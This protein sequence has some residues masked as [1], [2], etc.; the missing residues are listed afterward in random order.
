MKNFINLK[1]IQIGK[2]HLLLFILLAFSFLS[3]ILLN[4]KYSPKIA[5]NESFEITNYKPNKQFDERIMKFYILKNIE[6]NS[7]VFGTSTSTV[8][9]PE[10]IKNY[11]NSSINSL[12]LSFSGGLLREYS[13]F[14][15]WIFK[16]KS[17]LETIIVELKYY[18]LSEVD[19]GGEMPFELLTKNKQLINLISL[20]TTK[21]TVLNL[22]REI[23]KQKKDKTNFNSIEKKYFLKGMRYY[24]Q[25]FKRKNNTDQREKHKKLI[26]SSR[27]VIFGSKILNNNYTLLDELVEN[28]EK[29]KINLIFYFGPAYIDL[30]KFEKYKYLNRELKL[31]KNILEKTKVQNIYYF[32]TFS[33][34]N[35]DDSY[36][37]T[38]HTHYDYDAGKIILKNLLNKDNK[39]NNKFS[40]NFTKEN[41]KELSLKIKSNYEKF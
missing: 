31:I 1:K 40:Y 30:L 41:F 35:Y 27:K 12:N 25:F 36:Y 17:D 24:P 23:F 2:F 13:Q 11:S 22:S 20:D 18:S 4:L 33:D 28:S 19:F 21:K 26:K 38:N 10:L 6:A 29:R 14:L 37:E 39:K 16:N 34:L 32:N 8:L 15:N 9:D 7:F 5:T 3:I